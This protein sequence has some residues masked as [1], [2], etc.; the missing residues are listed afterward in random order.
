M[1]LE[2]NEARAEELMIAAS[3]DVNVRWQR[4]QRLAEIEGNIAEKK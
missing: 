4:L 2:S 1:L 3:Q